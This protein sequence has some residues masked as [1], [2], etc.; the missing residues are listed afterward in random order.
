MSSQPKYKVGQVVLIDKIFSTEKERQGRM[1]KLEHVRPAIVVEVE[2]F[3]S[4]GP[5]YK[6]DWVDSSLP[7]PKIRYWESDILGT[8]NNIQQTIEN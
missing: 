7:R 8:A 4:L 3:T 6:I 2:P 1:E 5:C